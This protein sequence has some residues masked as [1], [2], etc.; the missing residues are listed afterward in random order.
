MANA[1]EIMWLQSLIESFEYHVPKELVYGATA[2]VL[3]PLIQYFM[4]E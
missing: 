4:E 3:S 1:T 2:W